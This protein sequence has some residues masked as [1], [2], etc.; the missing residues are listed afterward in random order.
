M[1][2]QQKFPRNCAVQITGEMNG[3]RLQHSREVN[4]GLPRTGTNR[5]LGALPIRRFASLRS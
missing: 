2:L 4:P 1:E 3:S 5:R